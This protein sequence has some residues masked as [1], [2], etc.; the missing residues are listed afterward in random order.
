MKALVVSGA[1]KDV[2]SPLEA[3]AMIQDVFSR[4][5]YETYGVPFCDGGEYTFEVLKEMIPQPQVITPE[6]VIS[7]AGIPKK[8]RYLIDGE[9]T[10][11]IVSSEI[12][13]LLP[14][15]DAYKNPLVLTDYGFGQLI[16]DA[17]GRGIR[18][19]VLYLGGTS[20][21]SFGMGMIQSLGAKLYDEDGG[22]LPEPVVLQDLKHLSRIQVDSVLYKDISVTV[23]ADGNAHADEMKGITS[24]KV[25]KAYQKERDHIVQETEEI[26]ARIIQVTG[27]GTERDFSGAAG[28][29]RYGIDSLFQ[30][31][32]L[33]G[34]PYFIDLL[35][36]KEKIKDCDLVVTGE[37]R[38]D[39]TACGKAPASV[40]AMAKSF[41]K[42]VVL[43]CGQIEK[44]MRSSCDGGI[45][46]D[47]PEAGDLG[48][49]AIVT[50]QEYYDKH[51]LEGSYAE[52]IDQY[53]TLTPII[54]DS[55]IGRLRP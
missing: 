38:Y 30:A 8:S 29:L 34:G 9:K 12:L 41:G 31:E 13:R 46:R 20:T 19:L 36:I 24:L 2:F 23:V 18:K 42:P 28:G 51:P 52:L 47:E 49:S 39:N 7:P 26:K 45:I 1:F 21:V 40:A 37:G 32:Y 17:L 43:V 15:E 53:R 55:L 14:K 50:C 3:T 27:Q 6:G 5:G 44:S 4:H 35:K 10:A 22:V 33:P 54:L 25:G 11:H 48:I 16:G